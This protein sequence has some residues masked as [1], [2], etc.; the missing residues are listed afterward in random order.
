MNTSS[1]PD[2]EMTDFDKLAH[3]LMFLTVSGTIFF[4]NTNYFKRSISVR[5]IFFGSFLFSLILSGLIEIFQEYLPITRTGD[6][7]DFLYD[8]IGIFVG[9]LICLLINRRL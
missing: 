7:M 1:F 6:W 8:A 3:F 9:F 2:I 5:R 4:E